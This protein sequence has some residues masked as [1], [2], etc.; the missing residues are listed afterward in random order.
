MDSIMN[1]AETTFAGIIGLIDERI[2]RIMYRPRLFTGIVW[3]AAKLAVR[4][5]ATHN[6][7]LEEVFLAR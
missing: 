5:T 6:F 3:M 1:A 4:R 7:I 2:P